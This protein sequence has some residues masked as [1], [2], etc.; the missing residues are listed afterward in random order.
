MFWKLSSGA[1]VIQSSTLLQDPHPATQL[2]FIREWLHL[3]EHSQAHYEDRRSRGAETGGSF[4]L[5]LKRTDSFVS[6]V[7]NPRLWWRS[8]FSAFEKFCFHMNLHQDWQSVCRTFYIFANV[9][10][11]RESNRIFLINYVIKLI[12]Y[13]W[14]NFS[15]GDS[16]SSPVLSSLTSIYT[17][18]GVHLW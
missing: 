13:W 3:C 4:G 11:F 2:L 7:S 18:I 15:S 17:F 14:L 10:S 16:S 12:K 5:I 6:L 1:L 9:Y 8:V